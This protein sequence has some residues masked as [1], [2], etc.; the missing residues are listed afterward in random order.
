MFGSWLGWL[1]VG[2]HGAVRGCGVRSM[3]GP[4]EV[5]ALPE[6]PVPGSGQLLLSVRV[7]GIGPWDGLLYTGGWDVG[8][9]LP[10]ALG[11]EGVGTVTAGRSG[12]GLAGSRG[13][14]P[15]P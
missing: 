8:L 12:G 5:L 10:A 3:T 14:G 13:P 2:Y 9:R 6:P 11:V 15:R 4:V 7:A 1:V